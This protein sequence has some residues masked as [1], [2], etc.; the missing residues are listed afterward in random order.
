MKSKVFSSLHPI[1]L[2]SQDDLYYL[3]LAL[4]I[5]HNMIV[6]AKI[7][8]DEVECASMHNSVNATEQES[9]NIEVGSEEVDDENCGE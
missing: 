7:E 6:K 5:I 1:N 2:H 8:C 9:G 4:I 3:V